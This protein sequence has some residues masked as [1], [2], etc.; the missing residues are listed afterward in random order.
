MAAIEGFRVRNFKSLSDVT[1][2]QLWNQR[3]NEPFTPMTA[4]IGKNGVGK[5]A[6]ECWNGRV[7][8]LTYKADLPVLA[9]SRAAALPLRKMTVP[10]K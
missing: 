8:C 4:V 2:G 10:S 7:S 1:L 5:S 6:I 3:Q 9:D